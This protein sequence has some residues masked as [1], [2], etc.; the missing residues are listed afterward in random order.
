MNYAIVN[1]A[2]RSFPPGDAF[3]DKAVAAEGAAIVVYLAGSKF[4]PDAGKQ[5]ILVELGDECLGRHTGEL[6]GEEG[7]NVL[8]FARFRNG[9]DAPSALVELVRQKNTA[10]AALQAAV[11]LF[12]S[13][14]L[15]VAVCTD[16]AGRIIDR[17]VRPKY[18]AALRLL[19]EGLATQSDIDLTCKL[20]LGYPDGPIERTVRGG[21][22]HHY[23][24]CRA[25]FEIYGTAAYAPARRAVVAAQ[26]RD[27]PQN[28]S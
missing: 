2:S 20:G 15:V 21:L 26:R 17:L 9:N 19:D 24:V 12:E 3:L 25:L 10:Q 16:Q 18:N 13:A 11:A 23:D 7:S 27:S 14:G 8:G 4:Q 5:A 1:G 22:E 28:R 6:Q